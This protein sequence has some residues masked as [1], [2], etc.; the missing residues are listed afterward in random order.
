MK[1]TAVISPAMAKKVGKP[2]YEGAQAR[3]SGHVIKVDKAFAIK[4]ELKEHGYRFSSTE[5]LWLL[6]VADAQLPTEKAW[7]NKTESANIRIVALDDNT[8]ESVYL[9]NRWEKTVRQ[10]RRAQGAR[11]QI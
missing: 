9:R 1:L 8:I 10:K 3:R 7:V 11:I 6:E 2:H 4:D 5:K